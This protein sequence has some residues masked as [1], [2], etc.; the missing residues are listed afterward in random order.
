MTSRLRPSPFPSHAIAVHDLLRES[1]ESGLELDHDGLIRASSSAVSSLLGF[2]PEDV[3]NTVLRDYVHPDDQ[4]IFDEVVQHSGPAAPSV[5]IRFMRHRRSRPVSLSIS[6]SKMPSMVRVHLQ[7]VTSWR[8]VEH[9][10]RGESSAG[11]ELANETPT[12]VLQLDQQCRCIVANQS[13]SEATGT[14]TTA[15]PSLV[16]LRSLDEQTLEALR[17][18]LPSLCTGISF[19]HTSLVRHLD[20]FVSKF[21]IAVAPIV[22]A[23]QVF[24]GFVLI[25]ADQ[26]ALNDHE[27]ADIA[28]T[29]KFA[30]LDIPTA[31]PSAHYSEPA[32][33]QSRRSVDASRPAF[34]HAGH[35]A[36]TSHDPAPSAS[37]PGQFSIPTPQ[38]DDDDDLFGL[39][40]IPVEEVPAQNVQSLLVQAALA[41][42]ESIGEAAHF[43]NTLVAAPATFRFTKTPKPSTPLATSTT[44]LS[45]GQEVEVA[46]PIFARITP[47]EEP[48]DAP[49]P[50]PN[51]PSLDDDSLFGSFE[52]ITEAAPPEVRPPSKEIAAAPNPL[53]Q[54]AL[55]SVL[56][57][58]RANV[59]V[60]APVAEAPVG[61]AASVMEVASDSTPVDAIPA[62]I[63]PVAAYEPMIVEEP[64]LVEEPV[65]IAEPA[66]IAEP[67][68]VA[69]PMHVAEPE[70]VEE[71]ALVD[72]TVP[73]ESDAVEPVNVEPI[74]KNSHAADHLGLFDSVMVGP[75]TIAMIEGQGNLFDQFVG[76][77]LVKDEPVELF[78]NDVSAQTEAEAPPAASYI[79]TAAKEQLISHLD[80][81]NKDGLSE[82][83][84][85]ALIFIDVLSTG[86]ET[87]E[88]RRYDLQILERR[89]RAA[90]RQH[91]YAAPLA[92]EGFVIAARGTF[93][94]GDLEAMVL[95]L[96]GRLSQPLR[97]LG[98]FGAPKLCVAGVRSEADEPDYQIITRAER[99]R[100]QAIGAGAG[101]IVL[102]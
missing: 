53:M 37:I 61:E 13:W 68:L 58:A 4:H 101:T 19:R 14:V 3:T 83:V 60:D 7:D 95:R 16:W 63:E 38:F 88:D 93:A 18:A 52:I 31:T 80:G 44:D 94:P 42:E 62:Q 34:S 40:D 48:A 64:M 54:M 77:E 21:A 86:S 41:S 17:D 33:E 51:V 35:P 89:L 59:V 81:L 26:G 30:P 97:G 6:V 99:A 10:L 98:Q 36:H 39:G 56:A 82:I 23:S 1:T 75:S 2:K 76:D 66:L 5:E 65:F 55:A 24:C 29:A 73:E 11:I 47:H 90:T 70:F 102:L 28:A 85:V 43:D 9:L 87:V 57:A 84:S 92:D 71:A 100:A 8:V 27:L 78:T 12:I 22:D 49:A 25:G 45:S 74:D 69:E 32:A 50:S 96:M 67:V 46:Q 72:A 15:D 79:S 20:G 91:E